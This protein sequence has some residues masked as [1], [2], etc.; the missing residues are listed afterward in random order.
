L[1]Y[2]AT[3]PVSLLMILTASMTVLAVEPRGKRPQSRE[4]AADLYVIIARGNSPT[5]KNSGLA[6]QRE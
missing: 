5:V 1:A 6:V 2:G 4:L 3:W